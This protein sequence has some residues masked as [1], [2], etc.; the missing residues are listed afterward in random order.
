MRHTTHNTSGTCKVYPGTGKCDMY[1]EENEE[2]YKYPDPAYRAAR[3]DSKRDRFLGSV[4]GSDTT[5]PGESVATRPRYRRIL[6]GS[7]NTSKHPAPRSRYTTGFVATDLFGG[8]GRRPCS[9]ALDIASRRPSHRTRKDD[10]EIDGMQ[11]TRTHASH[12]R[13]THKD[14]A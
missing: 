10:A 7:D 8:G 14:D 11:I 5:S 6:D 2:F 13:H 3:H 1:A 9:G 4:G 12:S